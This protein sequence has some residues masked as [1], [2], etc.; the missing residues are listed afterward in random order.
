MDHGPK[1][2]EKRAALI[3]SILPEYTTRHV[4]VTK[5]RLVAFL[6]FWA[7]YLYFMRDVLDQTKAVAAIVSATFLVT[8]F[9]YYNVMRGRLLILSFS[10]ELLADL[11]ALTAVLY[12]TGGPHSSYFTIYILYVLTAG[13]LYNHYLAAIVAASAAAYYGIFLIL[14]HYGVI[15]PLIIYYGDRL[16]VPTYTPFAHFLLASALLALIVY[17][18]KVA[19]YF[20]QR[21]ERILERRNRELTALHRMSSTV[22]S[23][24]ALREV[25]NHLLSGVLEGLGLEG[26]V[27]IHFDRDKG[28]ARLHVPME[29]PRNRAVEEILGRPLEGMEFPMDALASPVTSDIMRHRVIFRREVSELAAGLDGVISAE[30]GRRIKEALGFKRIVV[31]PIVVEQETLGALICFSRDAYVG[32]AQ[33]ATME[34]FANQSALSLEAAILIDRLRRVNV[35]LKE[36]NQVKSEFLATMSHELRTPLTAIIGFSELLMEGVMGEISDEQRDGLREVLHNAADLLEMINSLLDLTKI[37][38]GRMRLDVRCF[39]ISEIMRRVSTTLTPLVQKKGQTMSVEVEQ[40][41]PTLTG[42][43]RKIQQTILNLM[44]N[45]N[46]FTPPEGRISARVRHYRSA[47]QAMETAGWRERFEGE[48]LAL[49]GGL[50]EIVVEDNGIGIPP[51]HIERVFDMFHQADSSSTRNFGGTGLGLALAKK[52]IEMHGGRIW[53]E[54]ELG[55]GARFTILIP[56]TFSN[57]HP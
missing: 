48:D 9:A 14:C 33:L 23:A 53:V 18:V 54:S 43:E 3:E 6:G 27:M 32:D 35:E 13:I 25:I 28:V 16:P 7:V 57:F 37:E 17:T 56:L 15:P 2:T 42:D 47:E 34:A 22:R 19:S 8:G 52:F 45:A 24:Q 4:F 26:A 46:K 1:S 39:E 20:S 10:V 50:V 5:L 51:D 12:L 55:K 44:A 30:Q 40:G 21:R 36:A 29:H 38:S 11:T 41:I 49:D 31:V